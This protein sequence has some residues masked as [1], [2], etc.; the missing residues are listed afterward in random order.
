M[1]YPSGAPVISAAAYKRAP[2]SL[3]EIQHYP[4]TDPKFMRLSLN[5]A[6]ILAGRQRQGRRCVETIAWRYRQE[7]SAY[8]N[9]KYGNDN[10]GY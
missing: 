7:M 8:D 1:R 9:S 3:Q 5:C 2:D 6:S 4:D 10:S